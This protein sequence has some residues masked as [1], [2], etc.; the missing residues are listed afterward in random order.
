MK[1]RVIALLLA[2]CLAA[3]AEGA[4][5]VN[6]A[7]MEENLIQGQADLS[8]QESLGKEDVRAIENAGSL[9]EESAENGGEVCL[10]GESAE[11]IEEALMPGESAEDGGEMSLSEESA[12][13]IEEALLP[14]KSAEDG[15]EVLALKES[16]KGS[17]K[18][19]IPEESAV[20]AEG[21]RDKETDEG[22]V[23]EEVQMG[24]ASFSPAAAQS[25]QLDKQYNGSL[26]ESTPVR[27]YKFTL[28][29]SGLLTINARS[30]EINRLYYV[31]YYGW[32]TNNGVYENSDYNS[33]TGVNSMESNWRLTAGT[34]Y[35]GIGEGFDSYDDSFGNDEVTAG[36][37]R[38][39]LSLDGVGESF[40]ETN[41]GS[42]N[43]IATASKISLKKAYTGQIALNDEADYFKFT[44]SKPSVLTL[45]M[46]VVTGG[47]MDYEIYGKS[48]ERICSGNLYQGYKDSYH[49]TKG[50]YY[51][52][53]S[54]YETKM[55]KFKLT[56]KSVAE[57]FPDVDG[58]G[59]NTLAKAN[60][61]SLGKT[62]KGQIAQNDDVDYFKFTLGKTQKMSLS[63]SSGHTLRYRI[64]DYNGNLQWEEGLS[65]DSCTVELSKGTYYL[66]VHSYYRNCD[67][68]SFRLSAYQPVSAQISSL[69]NTAKG[70]KISWNSVSGATG[71]KIYRKQGKGSYKLVK[72]IKKGSA[73]SFTDKKAKNKKTY[74]YKLKTV[75]K[76]YSSVY[77]SAKSIYCLKSKS[78]VKGLS[79]ASG[80]F[81]VKIKKVSGA[82]GY[83][84]QY[85]RSSSFSYPSKKKTKKTS[86]KVSAYSSNYYKYTY[87]VRVRAYKKVGKKT[88]YGPW[89]AKR[90][91]TL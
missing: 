91:I 69:E 64:Y 14:E 75:E 6:A 47:N 32:A 26:T 5:S 36:T 30:E 81:N 46:L 4:M 53:L 24:A 61:I 72:T 60:K 22:L 33:T 48:G 84:V 73:T 9:P 49:L 2:V 59:N 43:S 18:M 86:V 68:Y 77:S 25:I 13:E 63:V 40:K 8:S 45:S 34:Y 50:T 83:Q 56:T 12:E 58:E 55:Y 21:R 71:Y 28:S 17:S 15:G 23:V 76:N 1:K 20:K 78:A 62:Y 80:G 3:G 87:Y 65:S 51:L 67:T 44:L 82:S 7:V 85:S 57:S 54:N 70:V 39:K 52:R 11:G 88:Y 38:F 35:L 79:K 41:G 74:A 31:L 90:W 27:F 29:Q 37:F 66:G 10:S 16:V 89:S 19:L 42:N